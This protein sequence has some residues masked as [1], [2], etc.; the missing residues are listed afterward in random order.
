[1]KASGTLD[2]IDDIKI[3]F[4][5]KINNIHVWGYQEICRLLDLYQDIRTTYSH[6]VTPGD[7]I[8]ALLRGGMGKARRKHQNQDIKKI[9]ECWL[10][11]EVYPVQSIY[12][13]S[14]PP[15]FEDFYTEVLYRLQGCDQH[16][17]ATDHLKTGSYESTFKKLKSLQNKV[18]EHNK[19]VAKYVIYNER[20]LRERISQAIPSLKER[21][22]NEL[23]VLNS[24]YMPNV[25]LHLRN[26]ARESRVNL[27][28]RSERVNG[29]DGFELYSDGGIRLA[30]GSRD[31]ILRLK[32][33]LEEYSKTFAKDYRK[34]LVSLNQ[35]RPLLD[36]FQADIHTLIVKAKYGHLDG[37]CEFERIEGNLG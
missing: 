30:F 4:R 5:D 20:N 25:I 22:Y 32:T 11:L 24:Y 27:N 21:G 1:M 37:K 35:I 14:Y 26:V 8:H 31:R 18:M 23:L 3:K 12:H 17:E 16:N 9:F 28:I 29:I 36:S 15:C 33:F 2:K 19:K 6:L 34:V 10:N 7:A 13:S